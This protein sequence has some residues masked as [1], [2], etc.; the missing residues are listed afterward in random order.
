MDEAR[1]NARPAAD[2]AHQGHAKNRVVILI[3]RLDSR[4]DNPSI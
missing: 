4:A 3:D 2:K 1:S